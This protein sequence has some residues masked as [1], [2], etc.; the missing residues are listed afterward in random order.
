M[1]RSSAQNVRCRTN[2]DYVWSIIVDFCVEWCQNRSHICEFIFVWLN[3]S[4]N[5]LLS[6]AKQL[7]VYRISSAPKPSH[8]LQAR[9]FWGS[10]T[11]LKWRL[12]EEY[13]LITSQL[14]QLQTWPRAQ[15]VK[16]QW[17]FKILQCPLWLTEKWSGFELMYVRTY[18]YRCFSSSCCYFYCW[19]LRPPDRCMSVLHLRPGD[20]W[21]QIFCLIWSLELGLVWR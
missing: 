8:L 14:Q 10:L 4:F 13:P 20:V 15:R 7:R 9:D 19:S 6:V 2:G 1:L 3:S 12:K 17:T 21:W 18:M 5:V 11:A 16:K